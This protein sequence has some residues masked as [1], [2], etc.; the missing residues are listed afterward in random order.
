MQSTE[1][2]SICF[3]RF[4]ASVDLKLSKLNDDGFL[5]KISDS[6]IYNFKRKKE[7]SSIWLANEDFWLRKEKSSMV[8]LQ[9]L[10]LIDIKFPFLLVIR[11]IYMKMPVMV[12]Q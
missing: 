2:I 10:I 5:L 11:L 9:H 8:I 1:H 7:L 3:A 4:N 12:H 6:S